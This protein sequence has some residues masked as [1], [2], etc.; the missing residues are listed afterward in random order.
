MRLD[1][2]PLLFALLA[3]VGA[4]LP[5]AAAGGFDAQTGKFSTQGAAFAISFDDLAA[6]QGQGLTGYD[7]FNQR[8]LDELEVGAQ[9]EADAEVA[10]EGDGVLGVGGDLNYVSID[11]GNHGELVG[12]RVEVILWQKPRGT[13]V[14][15]SLTW[16]GGDPLAPTYLASVT[17]QPSGEVTSDG[18]ERW[19]SGPIDWAWAEVVGPS[20][21]DL[22]DEAN[23]AAYGG[24]YPD[25]SSRALVD[26]L[27]VMDLGAALVPAASCALPSELADCG[28][29]G[30]CHLGRCVDAAL[31][32]G[33][34]LLNDE[35]RA[36]Y[37]DRRLFEVRHFEGGRA[38]QG[39][40]ELVAA[41]LI[42]LKTNSSARTF[43]PTFASAYT[44]L[45]DGHASAPLL[46]YPAFQN[47]GVCVHEGEADL[48]P[49]SSSG[50]I[51]PLVFQTGDSLIGDQLQKGDALVAIDGLP[52]AEWAALARRLIQHPGDPE[53]RSVVTAPAV[54]TA[55]LDAGAVVTFQRCAGG[56]DGLTPCAAA[57]VQEI[58]I[59]LCALVGDAVLAGASVLSY[60]DIG[61]CDYRFGRPVPSRGEL[62]N[63]DY[64]FAGYDD[65]GPVRFL[66]INGVPS[67]YAQGGEEWFTQVQDALIDAPPLL[68]LDERTGN[69]G[70]ID[71]VDWIAGTLLAPADV[72]AMDFLPSFEG[73][74]LDSARQTIVACSTAAQSGLGC[75]NGFR[76]FVGETAS[77]SGMQG[78]AANAKLAVL[79]ASDVSG[80][81]YL[82]R[83]LN[84]RSGETRVFGAGST[85]GAYGVI[86]SMAA[87]LGELSGGSL[88]VQDTIFLA[89]DN[90]TNVAF[91]TS[92]GERADVIVRQKQSDALANKDTVIEAARAWLQE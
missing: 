14:T 15:P 75:G 58:V 8:P 28:D 46:G 74:D 19:T 84:E 86:W 22:N 26:A 35:L 50:A 51:M 88:Q 62:Q 92:T 10:L 53:G 68:V 6:I 83:L 67:Y 43:W 1:R 73:G 37:I 77:Q 61:S 41:A 24:A 71:A 69:G 82:T 2:I 54:F 40:I 5:A 56:I 38:P 34:T 52:T 47:G 66:V 90:D 21:L 76:S 49:A 9:I 89:D 3:G 57:D 70:G 25:A 85:W 33:Q 29:A 91:A 59:D 63:T 42:P 72:F 79:I 60:Q 45:V 87:H 18:W 20:S 64:E 81:D 65:D 27:H 44:L 30:L 13:R 36:D 39:K 12:R 7:I 11:L 55:A 78:V 4:A 80:N 17:L 31:R 16:Y 48:L 23:T 32:A